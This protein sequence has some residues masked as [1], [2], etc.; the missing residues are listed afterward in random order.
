MSVGASN[1]SRGSFGVVGGPGTDKTRTRSLVD[2][3]QL[4]E[5]LKQALEADTFIIYGKASVEQYDDDSPSQKILMEAFEDEMGSFLEDGIISRRHKDIP[6]GEPLGSYT[7]EED[8]EVVV[9]DEV[10]EFEA[11]DTLETGVQDD[12]VWIVADIFN[13]SEIARET[14]VGAATGDLTGFSV[15]VF[16]KEWTETGRGQEVNDIDWHSTTIGGDEHIKNGDSRFGVAEFKA[17]FG[18]SVSPTHA[19]VRILSEL[20]TDMSS[21]EADTKGFWDRVKEVA[22]QKSEEADGEQSKGEM[23][24]GGDGY[25]EDEYEEKSDVDAVLEQVKNELGEDQHEVLA[26]AM[27]TPD[28]YGGDE[29]MDSEAQEGELKSA[30]DLAEKLEGMG[31]QR[32][33]DGKSDSVAERLD[34]LEEKLGQKADADGVA[35]TAAEA[36]AEKMAERLPDSS[37]ATEDDIEAVIK[38]AEE[39]IEESIPAAAEGVAEKMTTGKTPSPSSGSGNDQTDYRA[40]I[41]SRFATKKEDN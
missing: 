1:G 29:E 39:A 38:S 21:T 31:F 2:D 24:E 37:L 25:D 17:A 5:G 10:L 4:G 26:K 14:R 19:A 7:L 36:A 3:D 9:A 16:C 13:D 35:E 32:G 18:G 27:H 22:D 41:Q 8:A 33:A 6:V 30:E 15:T 28:E 34:S 40:E 11:G 20:P 12:E 23:E